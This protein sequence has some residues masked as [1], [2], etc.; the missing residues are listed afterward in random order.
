MIEVN[1]YVIYPVWLSA[2]IPRV[3]AILWLSFSLDSEFLFSEKHLADHSLFLPIIVWFIYDS[4]WFWQS[5][6]LYIF[7]W[8]IQVFSSISEQ[9]VFKNSTNPASQISKLLGIC[10][11]ITLTDMICVS[12]FLSRE[13]VIFMQEVSFTRTWRARIYF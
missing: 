6:A 3:A 12:N 10:W 9:W 7:K 8:W 11:V 4:L 5:S 1:V 13:W 2:S